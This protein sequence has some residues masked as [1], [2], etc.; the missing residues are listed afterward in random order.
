MFTFVFCF[1]TIFTQLTNQWMFFIFHFLLSYMKRQN[2][3]KIKFLLNQIN[4]NENKNKKRKKMIM[5][6][7]KHAIQFNNNR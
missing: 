6:I 4:K 2:K 5:K 7:M 1:S 3:T